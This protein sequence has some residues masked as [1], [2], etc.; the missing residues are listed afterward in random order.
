MSHHRHIACEQVAT[1]PQESKRT[2]SLTERRWLDPV[3]FATARKAEPAIGGLSLSQVGRGSPP[4]LLSIGNRDEA[5][6]PPGPSGS[7]RSLWWRAACPR[8]RR[9]SPTS[10]SPSN[11]GQATSAARG[12]FDFHPGSG[13]L[14]PGSRQQGRER[15]M[16]SPLAR[17]ERRHG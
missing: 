17:R 11:R 16:P 10:Q 12:H 9:S 14:V 4:A 13:R 5:M 8:P 15:L 3:R 1:V 6:R 2:L 7:P